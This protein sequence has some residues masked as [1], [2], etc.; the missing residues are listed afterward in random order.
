MR[1]RA[2]AEHAARFGL[3]DE[4]LGSLRSGID[5]EGVH[6]GPHTLL[7]FFKTDAYGR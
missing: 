2:A 1:G 4:D 3:D 6:L 5:S 7:P